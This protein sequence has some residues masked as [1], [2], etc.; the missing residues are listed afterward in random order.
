MPDWK[1]IVRAQ[2][3]PLQLVPERELEIVEELALHLEAAHETALAKGLSEEAARVQALAQIT[4]WPL[5]ESELAR[6]EAPAHRLNWAQAAEP[7]IEQKGG[8]RMETLWQDLRYGA[9]MLLKQPGFTLIAVLTLALGIGANTAIFSL[10]NAVLLRPLPFPEPGRLAQVWNS[11]LE[12]GFTTFAITVRDYVNWR[13]RS[14]V[15][16]QL[17][18][19]RH[20]TFTL[21]G[22]G[23][24]EQLPGNHVSASFFATF[25]VSP[26]LGRA[27]LPTEEQPGG[28]PVVVLSHSLWQRRFGAE[29]GVINQTVTLDGKV[30]TVVGVMPGGFAFPLRS[31]PAELWTP[32]VFQPAEL[33][34]GG[35]NL[36]VLGR[37]KPGF[38]LKQ[39][40][41]ELGDLSRQ[42]EAG[43]SPERG[44]RFDARVIS[45]SEAVAGDVQS[46]LL[47]LLGAVGCV[48]LIACANVANLLLARAATRY[49][50]LAVRRALG[51]SRRR[52]IAQLL[53]ESA[54]LSFLGGALGLVL[55][56]LSLDLLVALSPVNL[57]RAEQARIDGGVLVFTLCLSLC[58]SL[59]FGLAPA[60][61]AARVNLNDALKEG[62]RQT[63]NSRGGSRF[64]QL[65]VVTEMALALVLLIGAS[66]LLRSFARLYGVDSGLNTQNVLT[67]TLSLN[68]SQYQGLPGRI[69]FMR[70]LLEHLRALPEV[71]AAGLTSDLPLRGSA[72]TES[73]SIAGR[74]TPEAKPQ[75]GWYTA[76]AGYFRA[77]SVP[78]LRGRDFTE[79][80]AETAPRVVIIN[81]TL[82]QRFWPAGDAV[83]QY[84]KIDNDLPREIVG[85]V[86]DTKHLAL[87]KETMPEMYVPYAQARYL[88]SVQLVVRTV[89][90]PLRLADALGRQVLALN[91]NQPVSQIKT[92]AQYLSEGVALPRFRSVLLGLF[93]ALALALA[94]IGLYGLMS[95]TVTQR[96]HELGI[97]LALGAQAGDVLKLILR[98]GLKLAL[99]GAALGLLAAFALTRLIEKLLFGVSAT[100]PLTFAVI[101]LL[102]VGVALLAC[103]VPARRAAQVDP[104][105]ALRCE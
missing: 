98:Q 33:E 64:R 24:P 35:H 85:V 27:F 4:D 102:L 6:A 25:G 2:L 9:R 96:T 43:R 13:Q 80:D 58:T 8:M 94:I 57:P 95:Y 78:L 82:A 49:R 52:L 38:T 39:A 105:I 51:A 10:M 73:F 90:D 16:E 46:I 56:W 11:N 31:K 44:L 21:T 19:Y 97:R 79:Q 54:L 23:E 101:P 60:W 40:Q 34:R 48:L 14:Q 83:G 63:T 104:L 67:A 89:A 77:F 92:M 99:M 88:M 45:L 86:G 65:L 93:G 72:V 70:E 74:P 28:P 91:P 42:L 41:A 103:W 29:S 55:A 50:E 66:L 37:L 76:S 68:S 5:L 61:Q 20:W 1:Q 17:A 3:T 62:A 26:L 18:A 71:Q 75:A 59:L 100:D 22:G 15:F 87:D 36:Q 7:W 69:V 84:L 81:Q 30:Y 32:L 53:T 47:L 12:K